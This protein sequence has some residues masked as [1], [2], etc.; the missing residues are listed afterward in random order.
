M[1]QQHKE[2]SDANV[3]RLN[4][5]RR[6]EPLTDLLE[7]K[8]TAYVAAASAAGVASL[9]LAPAAN[10]APVCKSFNVELTFTQTFGFNPAGQGIAPINI[11]QSYETF[12]TLTNTGSNKGFFTPNVPGAEAVI[13]SKGFVA[14]LQS[15][16][17]IGPAAKFG[18]GVGYGLIFTY[19]P[20]SGATSQHHVGNL[21]FGQTNYFGFKFLISGQVH[22]GWVR[23]RSVIVQVN[24]S[25]SIVTSISAYGYEASPNTAIRV[26]SCTSTGESSAGS[27]DKNAVPDQR[28]PSLGM[29]ALGALRLPRQK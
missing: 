5:T 15:G 9:T 22:Y 19:T 29:L 21:R 27:Q 10:A 16:A 26:G 14:R 2:L 3:K 4:R 6:T 1:N 28:T 25:P 24:R 8:I 13:S 20:I 12:S 17:S 18:K 23:M 7:R 11:A